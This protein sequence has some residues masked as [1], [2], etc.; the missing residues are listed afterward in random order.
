VKYKVTITPTADGRQQYMQVISE[1]QFSTNIVL[2][3]EFEV[4]DTRAADK[5]QQA[6]KGKQ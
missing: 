1:D 3:G 5:R 6:K 4:I 2:I